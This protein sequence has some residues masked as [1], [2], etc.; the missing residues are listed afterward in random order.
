MVV[1]SCGAPSLPQARHF[2]SWRKSGAALRSSCSLG[3]VGFRCKA[4]ERPSGG[5][6]SD[7]HRRLYVQNHHKRRQR[8]PGGTVGTVGDLGLD[9]R[10]RR[11]AASPFWRSIFGS[12]KLF[13]PKVRPTGRTSL[14]RQVEWI[15]PAPQRRPSLPKKC[16]GFMQ[17][18]LP[19]ESRFS[20]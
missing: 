3:A 4:P 5:S 19:G 9:E 7:L 14:P 13:R 16:C 8:L 1:E 18:A 10:K 11:G 2:F 6:K 17:G 15:Q 12:S 20:L